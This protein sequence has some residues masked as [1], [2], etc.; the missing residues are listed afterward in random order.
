MNPYAINPQGKE[1][2]LFMMVDSDHA[3]DKATRRSCTGIV[4]LL[5]L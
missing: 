2:D 3:G 5:V 4:T 1:V